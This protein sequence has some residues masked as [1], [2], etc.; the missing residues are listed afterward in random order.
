MHVDVDDRY[1]IS[2]HQPGH[3]NLSSQL[4]LYYAHDNARFALDANAGTVE[5]SIVTTSDARSAANALLQGSDRAT[6][7][8]A[9]QPQQP[10]TLLGALVAAARERDIALTM[11]VGDLTGAYRFLDDR[12][13]DD[14]RTGRL[15]LV[16]LVGAIPRDLSPFV[17]YHPC[18]LWEID[19][20]LAD[21]SILFDIF[22]A[23]A[24][25]EEGATE[26]GYG[27]SVGYTPTALA[28][29]AV[30]GLE[31]VAT[32]PGLPTTPPI[33]IDRAEAIFST[34]REPAGAESHRSPRDPVAHIA[35][36]VA[37]LLP[38]EATLQLGIGAIPDALV[39]HLLDK[40]DLG[41]HSGTLPPSLRELIESGVA[42]GAHKSR[43]RG[44]HV[45]TGVL[46]GG[47]PG[48]WG[49][50]VRLEPIAVTHAPTVLLQHER[51]WAINS[52]FEI[53]LAG[54]VNAEY[55]GAARVA[56]AGGQ[57]DFFR[58]AHTSAGGG[59][60][61]ALPARAGNGRARIVGRLPAGHLPTSTGADLD[62]VVTE[63]GI[64]ELAGATA[65]ERAE[66]LVAVAHP[67]DR[68]E[69][70]SSRVTIRR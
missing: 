43:D 44:L 22:V 52:A 39:V 38:N 21:G 2:L 8:A 19:R 65:D 70:E 15:R 53:D 57:T 66:R 59:A 28:S 16:S 46:D 9:M 7:L 18:S 33:S 1:S 14:V 67:D 54:C 68:A 27:R 41:I 29:E 11:L 26:V 6:I 25:G 32:T 35:A 31:V 10:D 13:R 3:G 23:Q 56:S 5:A 62:Y 64:A 60:V 34:R 12:A 63:H 51:F 69:L 4:V 47:L 45:A 30:V 42:T 48:D 58:A 61:L 40:R 24:E 36:L 50:D 49:P 55:A 20:R 17:D 37:S